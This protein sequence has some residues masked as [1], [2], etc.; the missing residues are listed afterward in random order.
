VAGLMVGDQILE[1]GGETL[2]HSHKLFYL[3]RRLA[4]GDSVNLKIHRA[5]EALGVDVVLAERP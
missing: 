3:L 4:A 2:D 5:G 1:L